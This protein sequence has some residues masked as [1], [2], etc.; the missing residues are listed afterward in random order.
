MVNIVWTILIP[1]KCMEFLAGKTVRA[2]ENYCL[3]S[4]KQ[5]RMTDD[6]SNKAYRSTNLKKFQKL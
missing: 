3:I 1:Q 5:V 6:I 4:S 2:Q